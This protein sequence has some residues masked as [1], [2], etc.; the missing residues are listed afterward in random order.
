ME[1]RERADMGVYT[2]KACRLLANTLEK[3]ECT[4]RA[5]SIRRIWPSP[6]LARCQPHLEHWHAAAA[7]A[8]SACRSWDLR[9]HRGTTQTCEIWAVRSTSGLHGGLTVETC[10]LRG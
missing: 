2:V 1:G 4:A 6:T 9:A 5:E 10:G 8:A 7:R 3:H